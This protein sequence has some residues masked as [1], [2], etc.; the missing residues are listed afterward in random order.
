MNC[1]TI[2]SDSVKKNVKGRGHNPPF[3]HSRYHQH[4]PL[5]D[6][7]KAKHITFL[8]SHFI[9]FK[10]YLF[11]LNNKGEQAFLLLMG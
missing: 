11:T 10:S 6:Q 9:I 4:R 1:E 7:L 3:F 8:I 5:V 2:L